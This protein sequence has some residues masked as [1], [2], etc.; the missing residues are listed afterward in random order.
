MSENAGYKWP[1]KNDDK[2]DK[3][4]HLWHVGVAFCRTGKHNRS[5]FRPRFLLQDVCVRGTVEMSKH[6]GESASP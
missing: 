5:L 1:L 6:L 4:W 2:I 3:P